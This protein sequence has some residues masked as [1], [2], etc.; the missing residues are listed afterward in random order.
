MKKQLLF[1]SIMT[2]IN[3]AMAQVPS[4]IPKDSLVGWWP[5]NGNAN[6]LSS[7]G[8][9]GN[10][11]GASLTN[12]RKGKPNAAYQFN[13]SSNYISIPSNA[14]LDV[15]SVTISCWINAIDFGTSSQGNIGTLISKREFD[16]WGNSIF[17]GNLW[18][19]IKYMVSCSL[20]P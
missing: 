3:C 5:F 11:N 14:S 7:N 1:L 19:K 4:Y 18:P 16:G 9:N 12:D 17:L 6:D 20:Y 15:T 13:G 2:F 8:N 10:V